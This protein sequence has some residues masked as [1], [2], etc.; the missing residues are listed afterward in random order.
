MLQVLDE[1]RLTDSKGRTVSFKNCVII[2]TS[3]VGVADLPKNTTKLG[4]NDQETQSINIK[5]KLM[6][7][8][9]ARFKPEFINRVDVVII[10]ESLK[11]EDIR[12]IAEIMIGNLN[13]KL[14][15]QK[16]QVG[17]SESAIKGLVKEGY[18][19]VYGARPLK[20]VIEQK[21]EDKL[22][23]SLLLGQIKPGEKIEAKYNNGEFSFKS[24]D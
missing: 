14:K 4:F 21:I 23:E 13:K 12:K 3:N 9:R 11:E 5:E 24:L 20:R 6:E 15:N 7:A 2:M 16:I 8:L 18:S 10:F 1:G 17:F 19:P 22:A